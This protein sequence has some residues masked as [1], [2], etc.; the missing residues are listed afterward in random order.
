MHSQ[1]ATY[2]CQLL[3]NI[4]LLGLQLVPSP[5]VCSRGGWMTEW[6]AA[7]PCQS[8]IGWRAYGT[9]IAQ[10]FLLWSWESGNRVG[11]TGARSSC[12]FLQQLAQSTN[13][14]CQSMRCRPRNSTLVNLTLLLW[15]MC[16]VP[17]GCT[18]WLSYV[19]LL[20]ETVGSYVF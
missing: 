17:Q 13:R 1:M 3:V 4:R 14:T 2:L 5:I 8:C 12:H 11:L 20:I 7:M 16:V 15:T 9:W 6:S 10:S 19:L 18:A